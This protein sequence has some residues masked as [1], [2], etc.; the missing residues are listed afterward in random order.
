MKGTIWSDERKF[1]LRKT[2]KWP[3]PDGSKCKCK[4]CNFKKAEYLR[5]RRNPIVAEWRFVN[6]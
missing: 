5:N 6:V 1:K 3:C 2:N 4:E